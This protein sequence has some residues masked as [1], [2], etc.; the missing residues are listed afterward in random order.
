MRLALHMP[1]EPGE[2]WDL[3]RQIGVTDLVCEL[4]ANVDDSPTWDLGVL[5]KLRDQAAEAGLRL[6]VIEGNTPMEGGAARLGLPGRDL[7]IEHFCQMIENLGAVG[8]DVVCYNFMAVFSWLRTNATVP[9]RGGALS[10]EYDHAQMESQGPPET[11]VLKVGPDGTLINEER[12]W[13]NFA[14]F[15]SHVVPVAASNGVK[16]AL[17]PDDPPLS[18]IRGV[19]RIMRSVDTMQRAIDLVPNPYNGITFCQGNFAAM[20]TDVPAAIRHFGTQDKIFF[21]HF[22]DVRGTASRFVETFQDDGPTDMAA[23][24]R[25]YYEV[26]FSGP[27]RPDHVPTMAGEPN[28]QPGLMTRGRL[29]A[30]GYIKGLIDAT[31]TEA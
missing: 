20:G 23:A 8:V 16:L 2:I 24:L 25:A 13:E 5:R 29:F 1:H 22:R 18:P 10:M 28:T 21:V 4:P 26:G 14:Y 12:L 15:S 6:A 3:S 9:I 17:H 27:V 7:E 11:E 19:G 31:E 30:I